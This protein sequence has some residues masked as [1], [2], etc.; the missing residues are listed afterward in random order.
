MW[1]WFLGDNDIIGQKI[2]RFLYSY[3]PS[4]WYLQ[5]NP[6]QDARC[7]NKSIKVCLPII[8]VQFHYHKKSTNAW[9][10]YHSKYNNKW[11]YE[12]TNHVNI[13]AW[14][15]HS[16]WKCS[17][18]WDAFKDKCLYVCDLISEKHSKLHFSSFEINILS[19]NN[20]PRKVSMCMKFAQEIYH[21]SD[22]LQC[23]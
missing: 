10:H 18:G 5:R 8:I 7:S 21:L 12:T 11:N 13:M 9:D 4:V 1:G 3:Y 23:L 19:H 16:S 17:G 20:L 14:L 22:Y 15:L 2:P 6:E